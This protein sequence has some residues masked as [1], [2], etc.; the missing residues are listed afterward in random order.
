M[1]QFVEK[2]CR[3]FVADEPFLFAD[4]PLY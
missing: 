4:R 2:F 3:P 1:L